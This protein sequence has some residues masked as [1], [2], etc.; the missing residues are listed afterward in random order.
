MP[1]YG[2]SG[3]PQP[4]RTEGCE[5]EDDATHWEKVD[6]AKLEDLSNRRMMMGV[7]VMLVAST[8][9]AACTITMR[10]H[11]SSMHDQKFVSVLPVYYRAIVLIVLGGWCW[12]INVQGLDRLH[13]EYTTLFEQDLSQKVP[14]RAVYGASA[15][16][17]LLLLLN[18]IA[19]T[20]ATGIPSTLIPLCLYVSML[21]LITWPRPP[22]LNARYGFLVALQSVLLSPI[23]GVGFG[24]VIFADLLTSYSKVFA[25]MYSTVC[26]IVNS[27][28][29]H[30]HPEVLQV[31]RND[32]FGPF[33]ASL[34]SWLRFF[35]CLRA[36]SSERERRHLFNALKYFSAFPVLLF[37]YLKQSYFT[38]SGPYGVFI[39][40]F[41]IFSLLINSLFSFY[42]DVYHDW[43]LGS[44]TSA[45][46]LLRDRLV[47]PRRWWYYTTLTVDLLLRFTWSLQ[48][49]PHWW[50]AIGGSVGRELQMFVL[51]TLEILRRCLWIF[52]RCEW[53]YIVQINKEKVDRTHSRTPHSPEPN[54]T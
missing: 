16:F 6:R 31:C 50:F 33:V 39:S 27:S 54:P 30:F 49:S 38:A 11:V 8:V 25:D 19:F 36:Y 2:K 3:V 53:Q 24:H 12:G 48:L 40:Q 5:H 4:S 22:F 44:L 47:F 23:L 1:S 46:W 15:M 14:Y 26:V 51:E 42:W 28:D 37:S 20:Q 43:G 45:N 7:K 17:S 41:W 9:L 35:Q 13:I 29:Q 10:Y 52:F 21:L 34:P 32:A 18:M